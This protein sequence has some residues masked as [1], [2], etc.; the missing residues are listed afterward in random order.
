MNIETVS[1]DEFAALTRRVEAIELALEHGLG[2]DDRRRLGMAVWWATEYN[3]A[4]RGGRTAASSEHEYFTARL[5]MAA[6]PIIDDVPSL[7]PAKWIER[8]AFCKFNPR[9]TAEFVRSIIHST[10]ADFGAEK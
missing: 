8:E 3:D 7:T 9:A 10:W 5:R 1:P 2:S 6:K 4:F